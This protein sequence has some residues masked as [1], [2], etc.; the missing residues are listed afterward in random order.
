[1]FYDR[2]ERGLPLAW[3]TRM[4]ESMARLTPRFSANHT[5]REYTE[6]YYLPSASAFR[7]RAADEGALGREIREWQRKLAHGWAGIRF[8]EVQ[9]DSANGQ[10][11]FWVEVDLG[12]IDPDAVRVELYRAV[13]GGSAPVRELM[14]RSGPA[15]GGPNAH[16]Y[17]A[18][19]G[20]DAPAAD[21]TP[22]V[23][24][25]HPQAAVP[26]EAAQILWR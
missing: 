17:T 2:D 22:R 9:V 13:D 23:I 25:H 1:M 15:R 19:V 8:G 4:R 20:A 3:L 11:T 10:R 26:L 21:Y 7:D 14:H 6:R 24:P 16:L 5:V 18:Q 12:E